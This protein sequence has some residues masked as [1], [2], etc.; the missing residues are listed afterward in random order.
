MEV[1]GFGS[2]VALVVIQGE[3]GV[4]LALESHVKDG[5]RAD[6]PTHMDPFLPG[7]FHCRDDL[8]YLF[9]SKKPPVAA[10]GIQPGHPEPGPGHA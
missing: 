6:G 4:E 3:D 1:T 10:V 8:F 7:R 5:I 9:L 2:N